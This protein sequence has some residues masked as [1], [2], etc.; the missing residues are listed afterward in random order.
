MVTEWFSGKRQMSSYKEKHE[1]CLD[2]DPIEEAVRL[3]GG[4]NIGDVA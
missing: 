2:R 3:S 4:G 1:A